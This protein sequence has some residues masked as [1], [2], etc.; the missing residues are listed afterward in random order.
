V[1]RSVASEAFNG[2]RQRITNLRCT[3]NNQAA[4]CIDCL[5]SRSFAGSLSLGGGKYLPDQGKSDGTCKD[6]VPTAQRPNR[7][8]CRPNKDV[9]TELD[10]LHSIPTTAGSYIP[11]EMPYQSSS[12]RLNDGFLAPCISATGNGT[13]HART[14]RETDFFV[15]INP[16]CAFY[17]V[18]GVQLVTGLVNRKLLCHHFVSSASLG[19]FGQ[20]GSIGEVCIHASSNTQFLKATEVRRWMETRG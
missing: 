13:E 3:R 17:Q 18:T 6:L 16:V 5:W 1:I 4:V 15:S 9:Q 7:S 11:G 10:M 2:L 12:G 20:F 19:L 8:V 14:N